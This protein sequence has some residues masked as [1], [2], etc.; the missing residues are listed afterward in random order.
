MASSV[1][2]GLTGFPGLGGLT[3]GYTVSFVYSGN[4][5]TAGSTTIG[6]GYSAP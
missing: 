5:S 4:F 6:F 1:F 3:F 2:Y